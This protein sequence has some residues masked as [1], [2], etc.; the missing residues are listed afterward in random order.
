[1]SSLKAPRQLYHPKFP[2]PEYLQFQARLVP[3]LISF[4]E[5]KFPQEVRPW[6]P[7]DE[8]NELQL[9]L[10][11]VFV[12]ES[13]ENIIGRIHYN[14]HMIADFLGNFFSPRDPDFE[15]IC[16][17]AVDLIIQSTKRDA[18]RVLNLAIKHKNDHV[19]DPLTA[20]VKKI[21]PSFK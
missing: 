17:I 20:E 6:V 21:I 5:D 16:D 3:Y 8:V 12:D 15:L 10:I 13:A 18:T 4:L 7:A 9:P 1:M 14:E 19:F 2:S 11:S